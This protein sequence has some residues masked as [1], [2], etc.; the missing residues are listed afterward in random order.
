MMSRAAH[1]TFRCD[2]RNCEAEANEWNLRG[3][4]TWSALSCRPLFC[5]IVTIKGGF[6]DRSMDA[7]IFQSE[8]ESVSLENLTRDSF[9]SEAY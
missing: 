3:T 6:T 8:C 2:C 4:T 1:G 7:D 9:R 5:R